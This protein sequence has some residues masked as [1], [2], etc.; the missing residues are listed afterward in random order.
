MQSIEALQDPLLRVKRLE[1]LLPTCSHCKKI[2][3]QGADRTNPESWIA[4]ENH[5]A[6]RT[7]PMFSHGLCP[8]CAREFYPE[9]F[10]DKSRC[11]AVPDVWH[12]NVSSCSPFI[13]ARDLFGHSQ[14]GDVFVPGCNRRKSLHE[15]ME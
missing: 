9:Y 1:G 14:C 4:I 8:Q 5:I 12:P 6:D 3:M 11:R 10:G 2:R 13:A 15:S 7:E